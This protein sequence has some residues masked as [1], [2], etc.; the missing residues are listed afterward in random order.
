MRTSRA[1]AGRW[2]THFIFVDAGP[3]ADGEFG[4][5]IALRSAMEDA[6]C[7]MRAEDGDGDDDEEDGEPIARES[8]TPNALGLE[9]ADAWSH[10]S[11]TSL[12]STRHAAPCTILVVV[13]GGIGTLRTV[14]TVLQKGRPVVVLAE[15]GLAAKDIYSFTVHGERITN[16]LPPDDRGFKMRQEYVE[17]CATLLPEINQMGAHLMGVHNKP[18]LSFFEGSVEGV[19]SSVEQQGERDEPTPNACRTHAARIPHP[20]RT[21]AARIP[22]P[23]RTRMPCRTRWRPLRL[24]LSLSL[25]LSL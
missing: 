24:S 12:S 6:L 8:T 11:L 23:C 4:K 19:I 17:T 22:H 18:L 7:E 10:T 15:S 1:A 20:C 25:S 14:H 3:A 13:G 9:P 21:H 16:T 5:E 2:Q